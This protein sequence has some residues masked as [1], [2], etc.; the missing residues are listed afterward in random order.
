M[1]R[2]IEGVLSFREAVSLMIHDTTEDEDAR[3]ADNKDNF[4]GP[5]GPV[6]EGKPK[7]EDVAFSDRE[8]VFVEHSMMLHPMTRTHFYVT[9]GPSLSDVVRTRE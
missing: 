4:A 5:T 3:V 9:I 8:R 6:E 7:S 2:I 1:S